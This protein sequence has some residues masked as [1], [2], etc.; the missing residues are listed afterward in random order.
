M[1]DTNPETAAP[2]MKFTTKVRRKVRFGTIHVDDLTFQGAIDAMGEYIAAGQGGYVVTPNVD[3][4]CL[5][6]TSVKLR[7]AYQHA[8]L[9]LIDGM[10][11]LWLAKLMGN[12]LPEKISGSDLI[13]PL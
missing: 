7:E 6:E 2:A 8:A 4:V 13:R 11:L 10:P 1:T 9:S 5:A 3:H 12:P